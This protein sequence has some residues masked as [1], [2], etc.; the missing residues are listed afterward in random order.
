MTIFAQP[1]VSALPLGIL[2]GIENCQSKRARQDGGICLS[3]SLSFALTSSARSDCRSSAPLLAKLSS[4][5]RSI[6]GRVALLGRRHFR[7]SLQVISQK[8]GARVRRAVHRRP[9]IQGLGQHFSL[10]NLDHG[11][12]VKHRAL[13]VHNP[14]TAVS[15]PTNLWD[16]AQEF[17]SPQGQWR[18]SDQPESDRRN[19]D[20]PSLSDL[21]QLITPGSEWLTDPKKFERVIRDY[22]RDSARERQQ[23]H[24]S[25]RASTNIRTSRFAAH[26]APGA[27]CLSSSRQDDQRCALRREQRRDLSTG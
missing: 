15:L 7:S 14:N 27:C 10:A 9:R 18:W 22:L 24:V 20:V 21:T 26:S 13:V 3:S 6:H 25:P 19:S 17:S 4:K 23:R 8:P 5:C 12:E 16:G 1:W 2:R 11:R